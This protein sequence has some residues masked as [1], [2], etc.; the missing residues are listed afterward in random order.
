VHCRY[1]N[2][3]AGL[4]ADVSSEFVV[5]KKDA[6]GGEVAH[7]FMERSRFRRDSLNVMGPDA[8]EKRRPRP[9]PLSKKSSARCAIPMH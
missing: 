1:A 5:A 4:D 3:A 8:I 7:E 2:I 6:N 9:K